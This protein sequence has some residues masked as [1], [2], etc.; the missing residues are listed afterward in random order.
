[1]VNLHLETSMISAHEPEYSL[2]WL[3][4]SMAAHAEYPAGQVPAQSCL[5]LL[6]TL[7][8]LTESS[9]INV[10]YSFLQASIELDIALQPGILHVLYLS[11]FNKFNCHSTFIPVKNDRHLAGRL[12]L[13]EPVQ[14]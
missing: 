5:R 12:L 4:I 7:C 13:I 6:S 11:S 9:L 3:G 1:M 14:E 8:F 10:H 2:L